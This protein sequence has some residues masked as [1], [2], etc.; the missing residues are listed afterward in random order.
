MKNR[1]VVL[2]YFLVVI[3]FMIG[4]N[5]PIPPTYLGYQNLRIGKIGIESNVVLLDL[6]FYNPNKYVLKVKEAKMDVYFN[7]RLLGNSS[8]DNVVNLLSLDT[9]IVP[10]KVEATAL[11]IL[12]NTAQII[13]NP[14]VNVK[15]V[16]NTKAGRKGIYVNVPIN[17]EGIQRIQLS[18]T[19]TTNRN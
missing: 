17:Y 11:N 6:K 5:K 7:D 14:N 18:R 13:L 19:D 16:G 12:A 8:M 2:G 15:I 1:A 10:F 4:C 9:T 3:F